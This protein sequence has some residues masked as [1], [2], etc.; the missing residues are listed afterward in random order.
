MRNA[1]LLFIASVALAGCAQDATFK[2]PVT[3][4]TATCPGSFLHD[5]NMWSNY[6]VCLEQ[7]VSAGYQRVR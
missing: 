6:P 1:F 4:V 3:G 7:Y 5:L 2:H